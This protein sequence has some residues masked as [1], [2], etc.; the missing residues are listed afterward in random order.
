M[1][2]KSSISTGS[3]WEVEYEIPSNRRDAD[4]EKGKTFINLNSEA[5][6]LNAE[7]LDAIGFIIFTA[8]GQQKS[9]I[10]SVRYLGTC[11]S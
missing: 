10:T 5:N 11:L 6:V 9:T 2:K 7:S 1:A 8:N 4:P 3:L